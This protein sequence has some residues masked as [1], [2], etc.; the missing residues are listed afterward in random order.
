M[1]LSEK[2][3]KGNREAFA[4]MSLGEKI[5]YLFT[6][7][8][9]PFFTGVIA[10]LFLIVTGVHEL[11]KKEQVFYLACVNTAFGD[12]LNSELTDG[13]LKYLELDPKKTEVIEYR[14]LYISEDASAENHEYAYA[15]KMKII[16]AISAR[17]MDAVLMNR[18]AW[19]EMSQS[20]FL[21]DL[22]TLDPELVKEIEPY[23]ETNEVIIDDNA[24]EYRLNEAEEYVYTSE[25]V[26]NGIRV[27]SFPIFQKAGIEGDVY[28]GII[29]NTIHPRR[30]SA[31][32][33]F[34]ME[35]K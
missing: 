35:G 31:F 13:F 28:L 8:K 2:E 30:S 22:T 4:K 17:K 7:Y 12:T 20:G 34:V 32:V 25:Q 5:S 6:Y 9:F 11:T 27:N 16:G 3:K 10:V 23:A 26:L 24:V 14:D 33:T 15:S 18:E 19:E 1:K 21:K 29:E